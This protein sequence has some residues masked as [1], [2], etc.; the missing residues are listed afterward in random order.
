MVSIIRHKG[1]LYVAT[2]LGVYYLNSSDR[3]FRLVSGITA[4]SWWL[5]SVEDQLLVATDEGVFKID[6]TQGYVV[7]K[8]EDASLY[9]YSMHHSRRAPERI[10]IG[11]VDGL[12]SFLYQNGSWQQEWRINGLNEGVRNFAETED[13][14]LWMGTLSTGT[15][16]ADISTNHAGEMPEIERFGREYNLP[17]GGVSASAMFK[18]IK[19][20]KAIIPN[21]NK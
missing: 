8:S 20:K 5:L 11:L 18:Q 19:H 3:R 12:A 4:R 14:K 2:G 10:Y 1:T 15:I 6:G 17:K 13:G 7:K 21:F 9:A 16:R